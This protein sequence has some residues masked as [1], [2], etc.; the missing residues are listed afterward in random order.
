M[1]ISGIMGRSLSILGIMGALLQ[2][3]EYLYS[4]YLLKYNGEEVY[5]DDLPVDNTWDILSPPQPCFLLKR[6][7][8][9]VCCIRMRSKKLSTEHWL[10]RS[11]TD[12]TDFKLVRQ[13]S[14]WKLISE[15]KRLNWTLT[16][17]GVGM[18]CWTLVRVIGHWYEGMEVWT[19]IMSFEHWFKG[20]WTLITTVER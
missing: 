3:N 6:C 4:C 5:N 8:T 15:K 10:G 16:R 11:C 1:A 17:K 13:M 9:G 12:K 20:G 19:L 14:D 7:R 18:G 2:V